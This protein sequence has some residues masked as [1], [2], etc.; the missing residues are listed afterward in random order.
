MIPGKR[1]SIE[2]YLRIAWRR[3]WLIAIPF[4]M[5]STATVVAA[6]RLPNRYRSEALLEVV[7]QRVPTDYVQPTVTSRPEDRLRSLQQQILSRTR[8]EQIIREFNLYEGARQAGIMEDVI[9]RMKLDIVIDLPQS[10][11]TS[12]GIGFVAN[13]ARTAMRVT[14]RLT[15][16]FIEENL[17]DRERLAEGTDQFL[18]TQLQDAR[19]RLVEQ[20]K[21]LEG[22]RRQHAGELPS[23]VQSNLQA[24]QNAQLQVQSLVQT[25]AQD[26]DEKLM[27]ERLLS[28]PTLNSPI[29]VPAPGP[30]PT[31]DS[32][33][34]S[35]PA[36]ATAAQ[37]LD[38]ARQALRGLE[39][40]LKPE[41]PDIGRL[42]RT[43]TELELKADQE[44]LLIPISSDAPPA[45]PTQPVPPAETARVSRLRDIKLQVESLDRQIA[46]KQQEETRLRDVAAGYQQ[47][48]AGV[49]TRES[50]LM[51]LTR[52]HATLLNLY[53]SLLTKKE[54][55][56]MAVNMERRQIGEQ[57]RIIEP[58]RLPERPFSPN[59]PQI[60][61]MGVLGAL[62]VGLGLVMLL[63]YRDT[64]LR[65]DVDVV[66]SLSLPVLAIVPALTTGLER[67]RRYRRR[68]AVSLSATT[69]V[70]A[71]GA[72]VI[73]VLFR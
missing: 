4:V 18:E 44:A 50:E 10:P 26:R 72:V 17:K 32:R 23:Q 24:L 21:K 1:Y 36:G 49:P 57:F 29:S 20:E 71:C 28:D 8:L 60:Y 14:E 31:F 56:K 55:A 25:I 54:N 61:S 70:I 45:Q 35:A 5:I 73:W 66:S 69:T 59:R 41:H 67:R 52:D 62:A 64:S 19:G 46:Q 9:Q 22:Y 15:A 33:N 2:D 43:I 30:A 42:K 48:L 65:T 13:D 53:T 11:Q 63:E 58:A 34:P 38:A 3:K 39:L 47:R 7:S 68:M 6:S 27:L 12:F 51:E 40:R 16:L 37:Q